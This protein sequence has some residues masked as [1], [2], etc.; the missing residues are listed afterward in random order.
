MTGASKRSVK[1]NAAINDKTAFP[2]NA[3]SYKKSMKCFD[4]RA[5]WYT[6]DD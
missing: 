4:K 6:N 1:K 2:K 5:F 3:V